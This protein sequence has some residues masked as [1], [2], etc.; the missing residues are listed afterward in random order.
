M[1]EAVIKPWTFMHSLRLLLV[2]CLLAP[3]ALGLV[4]GGITSVFIVISF[5]FSGEPLSGEALGPVLLAPFFAL[6]FCALPALMISGVLI[7]ARTVF[8]P[9]SYSRYVLIC[10]IVCFAGVWAAMF[11]LL[12]EESV[13]GAL[14]GGS[15]YALIGLVACLFFWAKRQSLGLGAIAH[16]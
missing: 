1:S 4:L 5:V 13:V 10:A 8:G 12:K 6:W 16:D 15:F 14:V 3:L 2:A 9:L 11:V 7:A